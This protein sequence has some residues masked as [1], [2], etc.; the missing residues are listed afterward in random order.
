MNIIPNFDAGGESDPCFVIV[1]TNVEILCDYLQHHP[2]EPQRSKKSG[3]GIKTRSISSGTVDRKDYNYDATSVS[4][5]VILY[6]DLMN[7]ME[8]FKE[9]TISDDLIC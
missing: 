2:V 4:E 5:M 6:M 9:G 7:K 1:N 8:Q 3:A